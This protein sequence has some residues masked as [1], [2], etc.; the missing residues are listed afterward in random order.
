MKGEHRIQSYQVRSVILDCMCDVRKD[1]ESQIQDCFN[2]CYLMLPDEYFDILC[3]FRYRIYEL[4][5]GITV[6]PDW[7]DL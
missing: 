4:I 2:A 3:E 5:T 6:S 1:M 7:G